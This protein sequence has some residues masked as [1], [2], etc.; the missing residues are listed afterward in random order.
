MHLLLLKRPRTM[1]SLPA[2]SRRLLFRTAWP[3]L[4]S[5]VRIAQRPGLPRVYRVSERELRSHCGIKTNTMIRHGHDVFGSRALDA[6]FHEHDSVESTALF[7]FLKRHFASFPEF[8][9]GNKQEQA[10]CH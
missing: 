2:Q 3:E 8:R 10:N 5:S 6:D 1:R 7:F 9:D 4:Y